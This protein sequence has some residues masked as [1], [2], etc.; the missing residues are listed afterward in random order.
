[1]EDNHLVAERSVQRRFEAHRLEDQLWALAYEQVW[2]LLRRSLSS[3]R[4]APQ[5]Q[6]QEIETIY[7][8][9]RRA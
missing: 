5:P 9:A 2:P 3:A 1:M 8:I 4:R 7:P 6:G